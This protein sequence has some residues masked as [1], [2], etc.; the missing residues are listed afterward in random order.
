MFVVSGCYFDLA[1]KL[2]LEW[3]FIFEDKVPVLLFSNSHASWCSYL[4]VILLV[5][6]RYSLSQTVGKLDDTS[7]N[8]SKDVTDLDCIY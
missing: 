1:D 5:K 6:S 8:S 7:Y 2:G 3:T 4:Q